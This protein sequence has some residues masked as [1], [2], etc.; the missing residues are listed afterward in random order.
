MLNSRQRGREPPGLDP[1]A[2][3]TKNST[4]TQLG[5][6]GNFLRTNNAPVPP[7]FALGF[8][9]RPAFALRFCPRLSLMLSHLSVT[10]ARPQ[11]T[12]GTFGRQE[13]AVFPQN[14]RLPNRQFYCA[15][16]QHPSTEVTALR[17]TCRTKFQG[18]FLTRVSL[19]FIDVLGFV[20]V[21]SH[22]INYH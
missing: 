17:P 8:A 5:L 4:I 11:E 18:P 21:A 7:G 12:P 14:G 20:R 19:D 15:G 16:P 1:K 10:L 3:H 13:P 9:S 22:Y 6:C 2:E